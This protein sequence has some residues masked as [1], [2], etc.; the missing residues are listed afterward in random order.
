MGAFSGSMSYKLFFVEGDLPSGWKDHFLE[1]IAMR[2]F[3]EISPDEEEEESYGWVPIQRPLSDE[4]I[5]A[6]VV[7][8][9]YLN[10]GFRKDKYAIS[11][12]LFKARL[13]LVQHEYLAQNDLEKLTR[14][15]KD[16][17]KTMVRNDL[18]RRTLPGMKVTDMSW[19][20]GRG[21]V[22]FWSQ[23]NKLCELFQG[24]FEDTFGMKLLPASPYITGVQLG[25]DAELVTALASTEPTNFVDGHVGVQGQG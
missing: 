17:I 15:Q 9:D 16:D 11:T 12:D 14:L 7:Y 5:Y 3:E 6:Q 1:R 25:L 4:F 8:N 21:E 20:L 23:S 19:H 2:K 22:R 13:A 24:Y 18:K 10:L